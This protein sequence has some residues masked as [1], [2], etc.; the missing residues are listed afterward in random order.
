MRAT[1]LPVVPGEVDFES[2]H[3]RRNSYQVRA[4]LRDLGGLIAGGDFAVSYNDYRAREFEFESDEGVTELDSVATNK[5]FNYR[6]NFDQQRRGRFSGTFGFSGFTRDFESVGEEAPAPRTR[7]NSFAAY[8]L[9]RLDLEHVGFQFG[10][11]VEQNGYRPAGDFR[12]RNFVG[13]SGSAGVRLSLWAGGSLVANYQHS[14]RAPALEELYNNGPHPGILV[15]DIGNQALNAERGDGVDFSLRHT[16]GRVRLDASFYYYGLRNY[17]FPAFTGSTDEESGLPVVVYTQGNSR[18]TGA[19][20]SVEA[21]VLPAL[22]LNGKVDYVRAELTELHKPLPRIPPLRGTLGLDWRYK[23]FGIRPELVMANR[24]SRVFDNE[25]PTAG[26]AVF[27]LNAS[28][29]FVS[30]RVSHIIT[31][32][33]YNLGD[34]LY[35]NHLSFI[36]EVAPEMGRSL[37]LNYS[38]RF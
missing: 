22:W 30:G 25:T 36:K 27:N 5:N 3:E 31:L 34:A 11:R 7:Q 26:Y 29:T 28:Y 1:A 15:F 16:S 6:A 12:D 32:G 8:A 35:R 10:G 24:Q 23:A 20:A 38:L 21:R 13:F 17:V 14:F 9:E 33:G 18:Y 4:G 19:E 37:R 2:L